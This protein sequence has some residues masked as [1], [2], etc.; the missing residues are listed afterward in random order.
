MVALRAHD[1]QRA[2]EQDAERP[3][4]TRAHS[5]ELRDVEACEAEP[6]LIKQSTN[7]NGK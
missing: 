4:A 2:M 5:R 1:E 3:P 7:L 6:S